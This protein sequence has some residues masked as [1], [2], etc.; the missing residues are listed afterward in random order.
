MKAEN[1]EERANMLMDLLKKR[2]SVRKFQQREI[3]KEKVD[4]ILKSALLSPSSRARRPWEFV[5]VTDRHLLEEL[6]RCREHSS[7]FLEG[8][9]LGIVVAADP[10][11]CDVWIED[12]SIAAIIIQIAA[13]SLGLGS[14]WIQVRERIYKENIMAQEYIKNTLRIPEKYNIECIIAIGYPGEEK[15]G[16]EEDELLYDK[17]HY[18]KY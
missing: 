1:K 5:T 4:F 12:S 8:A 9:P 6:S 16:C 7:Q 17:I 13:Q 3:E 15:K 2:R 10:Y 18:N 11:V 14:C